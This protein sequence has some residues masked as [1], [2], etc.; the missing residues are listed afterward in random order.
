MRQRGQVQRRIDRASQAIREAGFE[1]RF[2]DYCE[3]AETPGILGVYAGATNL[4][5]R[6]VKIATRRRSRAEIA[7]TLEH[8]LHHVQDPYW[9]CGSRDV[10]GNESPAERQVRERAS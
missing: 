2:V 9:V 7:D 6:K 10:F 1:L 3:D 4:D 5:L 8:E